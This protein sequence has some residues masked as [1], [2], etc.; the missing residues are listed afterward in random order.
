[1]AFPA[2]IQ[3]MSWSVFSVF[4]TC[5]RYHIRLIN[6]SFY[7]F[8]Q[9]FYRFLPHIHFG[10]SKLWCRSFVSCS[11]HFCIYIYCT[12]FHQLFYHGKLF[13]SLLSNQNYISHVN[14]I[15]FVIT[16]IVISI[17]FSTNH[18]ELMEE[19]KHSLWTMRALSETGHLTQT[20]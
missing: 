15:Y 19:T 14:E 16:F 12:L 11:F 7:W 20:V 17:K 8:Y 13:Q 18:W 10:F 2:C 3:L 6:C 4:V 1:M 9:P 5:E